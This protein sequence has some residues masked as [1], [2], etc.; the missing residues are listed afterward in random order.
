VLRGTSS[1]KQ[2]SKRINKRWPA[3]GRGTKNIVYAQ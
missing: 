3:Q 1:S 2:R